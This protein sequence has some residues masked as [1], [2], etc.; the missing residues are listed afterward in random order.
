MTSNNY[1]S[2]LDSRYV[3]VSGDTMTGLLTA[4][5][6]ASHTGLKL[7]N[8][9]LTA[10]GG[11]V[12]FQNNNSLRFGNDAWDYNQ[13]AGLKY[14][15]ASKYIYLGIADGSVFQANS[16]QSGGSIITPGISNIF[17]GNNT[18]NKVWHAGNDGSGS[19]LDADM[20]DRLHSTALFRRNIQWVESNTN[21]KKLYG[22]G[23][24]LNA[25][26]NGSGNSN[27]PS[28]YG[29]L[30]NFAYLDN[31]Y[32]LQLHAGTDLLLRYSIKFNALDTGWYT[33]ARTTDNVASATRLQTARSLWGNTF[34]GT[35][36]L[37]GRLTAAGMTCGYSNT[38]YAISTTGLISNGW[39]RTVGQCGW[40]SETYGGG[41]YM[42]DTSW[43]R[44]YNN[45]SVYTPGEIRCGVFNVVDYAGSSWQNG[46]GALNV[47]IYNNSSQTPL[48]VAYRAGY[49][50]TVTG[51]NRLFSME[52]LNNGTLM[53]LNFGGGM[54]YSL[55][56]GGVLFAS[57]GMYSNG[58]VSAIGQNSSDARLKTDIRGFNAVGLLKRL[59]PVSFRW[60]DM[61]KGKFEVFRNTGTEYGLIA[62][63]VKGVLPGIVE[64]NLAGSGY[65]GIR[66]E[67]LIPVVLQ[68]LLEN[69]AMAESHEERIMRLEKE[70]RRLV[71]RI[72]DLERRLKS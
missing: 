26:G 8:T 50:Y 32:R 62:Q 1:T 14:Y 6:E 25:T 44:S 70:N 34:D 72:K 43:L 2:Y 29:I 61:A 57:A 28:T 38:S 40:Y 47:Q 27:F 39:L 55:T 45:K 60:N 18:S 63:E 5:T 54:K 7:S 37:T 10:L 41:W 33:L 13:W 46:K 59:H 52:L 23:L 69:I 21:A 17:V 65:M 4:K 71:K 24:Y 35:Q 3:N 36:N 48:I 58:Y 20:L 64:D 22:F 9:Y 49:S 51:A 16:A 31:N 56:S 12:I 15:H 66:Y 68:G 53:Y 30:V 42:K 67:K 19:G 11:N